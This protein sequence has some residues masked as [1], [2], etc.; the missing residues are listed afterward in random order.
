MPKLDFE[1]IDFRNLDPA[2]IDLGT[3]TQDCALIAQTFERGAHSTYTEPAVFATLS[4]ILENTKSFS[5][6]ASSSLET[7]LRNP[8]QNKSDDPNLSGTGA[9]TDSMLQG[10]TVGGASASTVGDAFGKQL[11]DWLKDCIPCSTRILSLIE[12]H[13]NINLLDV[14]EEDILA[15][16]KALTDIGNLLGNIDIYSDF[17]SLM[18]LLNFMCIPDLQKLIAL[19]TALLARQAFDMDG[20]IGLLQALIA[21]LFSPILM[22]ITSL[23]DQFSL[24]V[25]SPVDCIMDA[26]NEQLRKLEYELN[27]DNPLSQLKSGLKELNDNIQEGK[28]YI[29]AKM[30]FYIDQINAMLSEFNVGDVAYLKKTLKKLTLVRLISFIVAVI[31]AISKGQSACTPGKSPEVTELD[32]FFNNFLNGNSPFNLWVDPDGIIHV[33]EKVVDFPDVLP[34]GSNV[35]KSEGGDLIDISALRAA[36]LVKQAQVSLSSLVQEKRSCY[37]ETTTEEADK[38]NQWIKELNEE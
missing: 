13:P 29:I 12:L 25:V 32:N 8:L 30:K 27:P 3:C 16:L 28:E 15:K 20:M 17:C 26:I 19:L 6:A 18:E 31:V 35:F 23:L 1:N 4:R 2:K 33:D 11:M 9:P 36:E 24:L 38:V 21:P 34:D 22:G 10:L 7:Y 5:T 14:L 37:L